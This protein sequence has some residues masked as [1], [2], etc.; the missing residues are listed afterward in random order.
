[1]ALSGHVQVGRRQY[2]DLLHVVGVLLARV[3]ALDAVLDVLVVNLDVAELLLSWQS[4][5]WTVQGPVGY[6]QATPKEFL[7]AAASS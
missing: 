5:L 2:G 1:M 7:V 4:S 6:P 3:I